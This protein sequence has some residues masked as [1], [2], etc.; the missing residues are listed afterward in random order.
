MRIYV[1]GKLDESYCPKSITI[2][3]GDHA[4]M[5]HDYASVK[6]DNPEGWVE[7]DL[8]STD[9]QP[10]DCFCLRLVIT[11]NHQN[12]KDCRIRGVRIFGISDSLQGH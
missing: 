4:T 12:G 1:D 8:K 7:M 2:Q 5:M 11:H 9:G 3:A 6:L 10:L